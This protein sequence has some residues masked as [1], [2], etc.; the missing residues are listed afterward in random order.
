MSSKCEH[1]IYFLLL[2][3][4]YFTLAF[5][6]RDSVTPVVFLFC[7]G[8]WIVCSYGIFSISRFFREKVIEP[9]TF[10]I[11]IQ[12][13]AFGFGTLYI[14]I[15]LS[16]G[17]EPRLSSHKLSPSS[18][19]NGVLFTALGHILLLGSYYASCRFLSKRVRHKHAEKQPALQLKAVPVLVIYATAIILQQYKEEFLGFGRLIHALSSVCAPV[20]VTA[21]IPRMLSKTKNQ[22]LHGYCLA[23]I[24]TLAEF[25]MLRTSYMKQPFIALL[26]PWGILLLMKYGSSAR[27]ALSFKFIFPSGVLLYLI[28]FV[29]FPFN[30]LRRQAGHEI[31]KEGLANAASTALAAGVPFTKAFEDVHK[32]PAKGSW[33]FLSRNTELQQTSFCV[34]YAG[35]N[36]EE[37]LDYLI[38]DG[39]VSLIPRAIWPNKPKVMAS[40]KVAVF[41]G[42]ATYAED[43]TTATGLGLAGGLLLSSGWMGFVVGIV[44]NG[45]VIAFL[46]NVIRHRIFSNLMGTFLYFTLV[47]AA[48]R[49]FSSL[50]GN[51]T[52]W[53][54]CFIVFFPI[55]YLLERR[56]RKAN[57][58]NFGGR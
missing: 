24:I 21:L 34:Q 40:R 38:T 47:V 54:Y 58:T 7:S 14:G 53:A 50:D 15:L 49:Q 25:Y 19:V 37:R 13:I 30:Q 35:E 23:A 52:R 41:L 10:F 8:V 1:E 29:I 46:W 56:A 43:A 51:I 44:L 4:V 31:S 28:V 16:N 27:S 33:H 57:N 17:Y 45:V 55:M 5:F 22:R 48:L 2:Q 42:Q 20:L 26:V 3:C 9:M 11:V 6:L 36:P 12:V 18:C 32:L 39:V